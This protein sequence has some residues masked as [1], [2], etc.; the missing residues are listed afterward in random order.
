MKSLLSVSFLKCYRV[1]SADIRRRTR[2][3]Y[4][5]WR[6]DPRHPGLEFKPVGAFYSVR[7]NGHRAIGILEG[8]TI[9]WIWIGD[10]DEYMRLIKRK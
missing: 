8:D 1:L 3:A 7:I 4:Q 2:R 5:L 6:N 9:T 10:H